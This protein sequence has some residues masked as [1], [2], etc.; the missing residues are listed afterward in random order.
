MAVPR[1]VRRGAIEATGVERFF[2]KTQ[3]VE[4]MGTWLA[5]VIELGQATRRLAA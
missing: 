2:N 3:I 1:T 5:D 4:D